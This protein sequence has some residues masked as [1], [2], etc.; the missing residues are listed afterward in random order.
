MM[1]FAHIFLDSSWLI[2]NEFRI[3]A[4]VDSKVPHWI[5]EI[6]CLRINPVGMFSL[7]IS[8]IGRH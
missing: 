7:R 5:N 2:S 1:T 6:L 8:V 3:A 4:D